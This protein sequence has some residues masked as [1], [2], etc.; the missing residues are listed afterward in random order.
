MVNSRHL[1]LARLQTTETSKLHGNALDALLMSDFKNS[2]MWLYIS[3]LR[4]A[5]FSSHSPKNVSTCSQMFARK[6]ASLQTVQFIYI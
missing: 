2:K 6:P 5:H 3:K 1:V 4:F